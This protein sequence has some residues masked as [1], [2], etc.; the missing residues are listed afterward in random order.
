[1]KTYRE[2]KPN[3]PVY[4]VTVIGSRMEKLDGHNSWTEYRV[5]TIKNLT[6]NTLDVTLH[7]GQV[8]FPNINNKV[9]TMITRKDTEIIHTI[10]AMSKIDALE[11]AQNCLRAKIAKTRADID[12]L[13]NNELKLINVMTDLLEETAKVKENSISVEEFATMAL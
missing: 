6:E 11:E 10:Y 1:M 9:H 13:K 2:L 7:N 5:K 3:D 8:F 4:K 12:E